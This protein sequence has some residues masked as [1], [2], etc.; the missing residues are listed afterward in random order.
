MQTSKVGFSTRQPFLVHA[1]CHHRTRYLV[2]FLLSAPE[3]RHEQLLDLGLDTKWFNL[4]N[5]FW[6]I[7]W[8]FSFNDEN[9]RIDLLAF[10]VP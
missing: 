3:I 7:V 8:L 2:I 1:L 5:L 4:L 10:F 9:D 6:D